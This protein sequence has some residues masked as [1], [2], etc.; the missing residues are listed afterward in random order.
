MLQPLL[1]AITNLGDSAVTGT[2]SLGLFAYLLAQR[3]KKAALALAVAVGMATLTIFLGKLALYT[4]CDNAPLFWNLA[5]PSGH[6]AIS[7][8]LYGM[9]AVL[10]S[11]AQT[12]RYRLYPYFAAAPLVTLIALSRLFLHLHSTGDVVAGGIVGLA[13]LGAGRFLMRG[14]KVSCRWP[15]FAFIALI[16]FIGLFGLHFPAERL[17]NLLSAYLRDRIRLC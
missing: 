8:A 4:R 1:F 7:I 12:G 5:S 9:F 6:T 2:L 10:V 14:E 11:S 13:C 16:L 17:I 3:E 15:P